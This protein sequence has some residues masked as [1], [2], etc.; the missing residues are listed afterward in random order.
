MRFSRVMGM[1]LCCILVCDQ[2]AYAQEPPVT[3]ATPPT[4]PSVAGDLLTATNEMIAGY[5]TAEVKEWLLQ[6]PYNFFQTSYTAIMIPQARAG[7]ST[8]L[9]QQTGDI[10]SKYLL[11][12]ASSG[13]DKAEQAAAQRSTEVV[14]EIS[15]SDFYSASQTKDNKSPPANDHNLN[16]AA[17]SEVLQYEKPEAKEAAKDQNQEKEVYTAEEAMH[18]MM[19]VAHLGGLASGSLVP[20]LTTEKD[21][22]AAYGDPSFQA[23]LAN[24]RAYEASQSMAMNNLQFLISQRTPVAGLGLKEAGLPQENVSPLKLDETLS[25]M[26]INAEWYTNMASASPSAV[27]REMLFLLAEIRYELFQMRLE[28]QRLLAAQTALQIQTNINYR[29]T[30]LNAC[31]NLPEGDGCTASSNNA[32]AKQAAGQLKKQAPKGLPK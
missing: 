26:R 9:T 19:A 14:A 7:M 22:K 4:P 23:Y 5:G 30:L 6:T 18:Y 21:K 2:G 3:G 28:N 31:A 24:L 16:F 1:V 12:P 15:A 20:N 8:T 25:K 32:T 10:L 13:S 17:L 29:A 11:S 27:Q